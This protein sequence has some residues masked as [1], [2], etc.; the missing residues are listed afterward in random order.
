[1]FSYASHG[2]LVEVD[3]DTGQVKL[4]DYAICE[5]CGTLVNPMVVEGQTIGGAVQGIGTA[6]FEEMP[7]DRAGQPLASTYADYL[8]PGAAEMPTIRIEHIETPSPHTRHGIKG[9][10]EGGAIAPPAAILNAVNAA[11][12]E[13]GVEFAE[14]PLTPRRLLAELL[15]RRRARR[16]APTPAPDVAVA[17]GGGA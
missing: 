15:P 2:A 3:V 8:L 6:L 13:F 5:D 16:V 1:V 10:G 14:T 9:V 7:Y 12:A 11:L 17:G 4:L